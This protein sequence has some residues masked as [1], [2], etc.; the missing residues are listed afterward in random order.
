M[1][2][3]RTS[4]NWFAMCI[5]GLGLWDS[6]VRKCTMYV[7]VSQTNLSPICIFINKDKKKEVDVK[8]NM[9]ASFS[10]RVLCLVF[11]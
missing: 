6:S 1:L 9:F 5:W 3:N 2:P 7:T 8:M 10:T 11:V 4:L